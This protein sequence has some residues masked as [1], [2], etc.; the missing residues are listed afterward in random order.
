MSSLSVTLR[1]GWC[2]PLK[3][4]SELIAPSSTIKFC[5]LTTSPPACVLSSLLLLPTPL[6]LLV[7]HHCC[8]KYCDYHSP[9][10]CCSYCCCCCAV[11]V[12][13]ADAA[14]ATS[15]TI[16]A[17]AAATHA[18]AVATAYSRPLAGLWA[19]FF[20]LAPSAFSLLPVSSTWRPV[21]LLSLVIGSD[22]VFPCP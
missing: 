16:A 19:C 14:V 21:R 2:S 12:P 13:I 8:C 6:L 17:V 7:L 10:C 11:A 22:D 20:S 1:S 5:P 9:R 3:A 4:S 18:A 15:H